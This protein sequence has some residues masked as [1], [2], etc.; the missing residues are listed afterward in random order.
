MLTKDQ[1]FIS[2]MATNFEFWTKHFDS[3]RFFL[4]NNSSY[5]NKQN[6][7]RNT[8]IWRDFFKSLFIFNVWRFRRFGHWVIY[9]FAFF[10]V[11]SLLPMT[12]KCQK[13]CYFAASRGS[14]FFDEDWTRSH[15][16]R[17]SWRRLEQSLKCQRVPINEDRRR[18]QS[19]R[20]IAMNIIRYTF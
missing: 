20:E 14:P 18:G 17:D 10:S 19:N 8:L 6:L 12:I 4:R 2:Q 3:T 11:L 7:D 1:T 9:N 13:D 16:S 15:E 5:G